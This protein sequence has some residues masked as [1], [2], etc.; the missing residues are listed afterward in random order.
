MRC[1]DSIE[2][3]LLN[4]ITTKKVEDKKIRAPFGLKRKTGMKVEMIPLL[5]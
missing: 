4:L 5:S 2:F 1:Q 3:Q